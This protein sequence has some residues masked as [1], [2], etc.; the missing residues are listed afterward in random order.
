MISHHD[1]QCMIIIVKAIKHRKKKTYPNSDILHIN[2]NI[3]L[4][5]PEIKYTTKQS[6]PSPNAQN[7]TVFSVVSNFVLCCALLQALDVALHASCSAISRIA[8]SFVAKWPLYQGGA[9]GLQSTKL[10]EFSVRFKNH[11]QNLVCIC[12]C[13]AYQEEITRSLKTH[14]RCFDSTSLYFRDQLRKT[15]VKSNIYAKPMTCKTW[16]T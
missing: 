1:A 3:N 10:L 2:C 16:K 7:K 4:K 5:N 14:W 13:L 12:M 8:N 11:E 9:D 6:S 15:M